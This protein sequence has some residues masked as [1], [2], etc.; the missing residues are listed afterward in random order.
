MADDDETEEALPVLAIN[1]GG[2]TPDGAHALLRLEFPAGPTTLAVE[3]ARLS[4]L[5]TLIVSSLGA[6]QG[7]TTVFQPL[8][9]Q[10]SRMPDGSIRAEFQLFGGAVLT[11]ALT[12]DHQQELAADLKQLAADK[13]IAPPGTARH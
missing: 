7:K 4:E 8:A 12:D 2:V 1:G 10:V 11:F 13:T 6:L 3:R 5:L 9:C